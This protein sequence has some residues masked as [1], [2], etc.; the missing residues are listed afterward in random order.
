MAAYRRAGVNR[1]SLGVQSMF[2]D[3]LRTLERA[4]DAE[5]VVRRVE[6]LRQAGLDNVSLDLIYG[7]PGSSLE[8]WT[9]RSAGRWP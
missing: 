1:I 7:L 8:T 5:A 9:R 4:H 2:G 6:Q 3:E